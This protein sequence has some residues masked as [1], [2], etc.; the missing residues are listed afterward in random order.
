M[1]AQ[2]LYAPQVIISQPGLHLITYA[3][4]YY[5][6]INNDPVIRIDASNVTLD[7]QG[8][9]IGQGFGNTQTGIDGVSISAAQSNITIKNAFIKNLSGV[10]I[11]IG[12]A[13]SKVRILD[14][15]IEGCQ[16]SGILLNG[17]VPGVIGVEIKNSRT[18]TCTGAAGSPAYGLRAIK[19]ASL[20]VD[21][22]IFAQNDAST[23]SSGY[24]VSI[25]NS[26]QVSMTNCTIASNGG[27]G[28][29][30]GVACTASTKVFIN[31]CFAENNTNHD[32]TYS[33]SAFGFWINQSSSVLMT[34]CRGSANTNTSSYCYGIAL[35]D[36]QKN[37]VET[38]IAGF[39]SATQQCAG[40][41]LNNEYQSL[42]TKNE[43]RGNTATSAGTAYGFL[44]SGTCGQCYIEK[45]KIISNSG[46]SATFG[47]LDERNPST[48]LILANLAF[49]NG[50]NY[51]VTYPVGV[52]LPVTNVNMSA[53][54]GFTN[55]SAANYEN[56]NVTP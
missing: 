31:N 21:N 26:Q 17:T 46:T 44:L 11:K 32:T 8:F 25:E 10:G 14:C 53:F 30:A 29:A 3:R 5:P 16:T 23:T 28:I 2:T 49:N 33:G 7:F 15:W 18:L 43:V 47:I 40:F 22:C 38:S 9:T 12:N 34:N 19:A 27:S 52:M 37:V 39:N 54:P 41:L 24:G 56:I 48:N 1:I 55:I 6:D 4:D 35:Q 51:S 45:N 36:G 50:T 13:C 20:L 42:C